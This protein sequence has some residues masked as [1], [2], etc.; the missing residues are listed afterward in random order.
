[1]SEELTVKAPQPAPPK[2]AAEH[3]ALAMLAGALLLVLIAAFSPIEWLGYYA[4][5]LWLPVW[6]IAC[7]V[8]GGPRLAVRSSWLTKSVRLGRG[9]W[10]EWG[11][12]PYAAIAIV[13]FVWQEIAQLRELV[14]W[15][16]E[17]EFYTDKFGIRTLIREGAQN[18]GQFFVGSFMSGMYA[19][20]WPAFWNKTFDAGQMWP[21]AAIAWAMFEAGKATARRLPGTVA[22]DRP[23][24]KP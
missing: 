9:Q 21:A 18:I 5:R 8:Y 11:G 13:C 16:V 22:A 10:M 23:G 3:L 17:T 4:T 19:F 1:M 6:A 20:G 12:G 15:F 7:L 2:L 14:Q 24:A